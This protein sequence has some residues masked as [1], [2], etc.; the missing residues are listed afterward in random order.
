MEKRI[1][2]GNPRGRR[3]RGIV[4]IVVLGVL[5]LLALLATSFATLATVERNVARNHLDAVRARLLAQAGVETALVR[6]RET[7]S[8]T[9]FLDD[10]RWT[11]RG[12]AEPSFASGR[13]LRLGDR[14]AGISGAMESGTYGPGGDLFILRIVDASS[15]IN[16]NDGAALG[17]EHSVSLNLRNLH[18]S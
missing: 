10:S 5:T 9:G 12:P 7:A 13:T 16:V 14:I 4:L 11:H 3:R 8:Q 18:D 2:S 1:R 6:L 17:P 15:R